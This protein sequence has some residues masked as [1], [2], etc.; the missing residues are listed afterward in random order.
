MPLLRL[1]RVRCSS[2]TVSNR[3]SLDIGCASQLHDCSLVRAFASH[4]SEWLQHA[5][6]PRPRSVVWVNS[7][8]VELD[9]ASEQSIRDYLLL[10][11]VKREHRLFHPSII[12]SDHRRLLP[13]IPPSQKNCKQIYQNYVRPHEGLNTKRSGTDPPRV[14]LVFSSVYF[15]LVDSV[16]EPYFDFR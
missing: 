3:A 11:N 1:F 15:R 4:K 9:S 6:K 8:S 12:R 10:N 16:A 2:R 7:H 5:W 13:K 14:C